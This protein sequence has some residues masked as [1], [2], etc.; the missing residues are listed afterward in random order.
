MGGERAGALPVVPAFTIC[1]LFLGDQVLLIRRATPPYVGRWNGLGGKVQ[2]GETPHQSVV[3][4]V[5]EESGYELRDDDDVRYHGIVSWR[6]GAEF[7][8]GGMYLFSGRLVEMTTIPLEGRE[9]PEGVVQWRPRG[10]AQ[11]QANP[12]VPEILPLL[13]RVIDDQAAESRIH[14]DLTYVEGA[15]VDAAIG[16]LPTAGMPFFGLGHRKR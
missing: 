13:L 1:F 12:E 5:F 16:P 15:L 8:T 4:E 10:W 3:R 11:E 2:A 6:G 14:L 7:S 9:I